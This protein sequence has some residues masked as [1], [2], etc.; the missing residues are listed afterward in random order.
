MAIFLNTG[1][2]PALGLVTQLEESFF[3]QDRRDSSCQN[4]RC[5]LAAL[6]AAATEQEG[7]VEQ[8]ITYETD[9]CPGV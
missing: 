4:V 7:H 5:F 6:N 8:V 9:H 3:L 1:R 2:A